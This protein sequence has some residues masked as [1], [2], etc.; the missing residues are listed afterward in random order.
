MMA[1]KHT[2]VAM[3]HVNDDVRCTPPVKNLNK[4]KI[5][6]TMKKFVVLP[7][8]IHAISEISNAKIVL[9]AIIDEYVK[10]ST[11]AD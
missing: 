3:Q 1:R 2:I 9:I 4:V 7:V 5:A 10:T 11:E 8:I 6:T